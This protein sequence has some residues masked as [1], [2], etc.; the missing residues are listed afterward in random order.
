MVELIRI[1]CFFISIYGICKERFFPVRKRTNSGEVQLPM[2]LF[3]LF[4]AQSASKHIII[5]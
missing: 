1:G 4:T 3:Q 2:H 5:I